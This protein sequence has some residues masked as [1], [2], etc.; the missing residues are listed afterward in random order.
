MYVLHKAYVVCLLE[1]SS[2]LGRISVVHNWICQNE[3][4]NNT[5]S[6]L[7]LKAMGTCRCRDTGKWLPSKIWN[8]IRSN[9]EIWA[10][11]T[12]RRSRIFGFTRIHDSI[13][14]KIAA[15]FDHALAVRTATK[16]LDIAHPTICT[17]L[18]VRFSASSTQESSSLVH[19]HRFVA[20]QSLPTF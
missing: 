6:I 12:L 4:Y 20:S 1:L 17:V 8:L 18:N 14:F 3:Y 7:W 5:N 9:V 13:I 15:V 16:C 2:L 10:S 19:H 11:M